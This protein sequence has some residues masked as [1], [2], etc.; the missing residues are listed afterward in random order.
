M[1]I[2]SVIENDPSLRDV[3]VTGELLDFHR[4]SS[5]HVYFTLLGRDSRISCVLFR[6][7]TDRIFEWPK[8]GDSVLVTGS[9]EVYLKGG[10]Y[11]LYAKRIMPLGLGAQARAKEELRE[12]LSREG[13]FDPRHKRP[14]PDYPARV[15]VVTSP[16]GAAIH[17]VLKISGARAPFVDVVL[18]PALVQGFDAPEWIATALSASGRLQ[19][20]ECVILTRGG[21]ARDDLSVFDDERVVRAVR[22]CPVPVV[23]GIGHQTDSSLADM[24]ADVALPTPSAAAERVF[25]DSGALLSDLS[26]RK[27]AITLSAAKVCERKL[28]F[29]QRFSERLGHFARGRVVE[30]ENFLAGVRKEIS[31]R[32]FGAVEKEN[33]KLASAAA[34]LDAVSPLNILG[35]G[36]AICRDVDGGMIKRVGVL[37]VGRPIEIQ[38]ADG[39][40]DATVKRVREMENR[41]KG[42][43]P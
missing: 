30:A 23:T 15:A 27:A 36:Y 42:N 1:Q 13:L 25:P 24:A 5:G 10:A 29:L 26:L 3:A 28:A 9:V 37:D 12:V 39:K 35:R 11:Q 17:D 16:S 43:L 34:A 33:A 22:A 19:G 18:V 4:H 40:V 31:L 6:S 20:V 14:L 41:T 32:A 38:F 7:Y 8:D 21:G 2:K